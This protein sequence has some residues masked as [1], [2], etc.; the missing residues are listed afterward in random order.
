[1]SEGRAGR[2]ALGYR[3]PVGQSGLDRRTGAQ[4]SQHHDRLDG[5]AGKLRRD[6]RGDA[7]KA[8]HMDVELLAGGAHRFEILAAVVAQ[9]EVQALVGH[10]ALQRIGVALELVADRGADE[11]GAV[12]VEAL[13]HHQVDLPKVDVAEIDRDFLAVAGLRSQLMHVACHLLTILIPSMTR[14]YE[15]G[16]RRSRLS[17]IGPAGTCC[18]KNA[19]RLCDV[20]LGPKRRRAISPDRSHSDRLARTETRR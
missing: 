7:G 20:P 14:W 19:E 13:L 16:C 4:G 6:V 5:G 3:H 1:M 12:R 2:S 9:T 17:V 8:Q 18:R 10:R 15:D 11:V